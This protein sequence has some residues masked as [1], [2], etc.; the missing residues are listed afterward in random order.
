M[1]NFHNV[2]PFL[3]HDVAERA[4]CLNLAV[5]IYNSGAKKNV[6]NGYSVFRST[7]GEYVDHFRGDHL[8]HLRSAGEVIAFVAGFEAGK[9]Q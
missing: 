4:T 2:S 1:P 5:S 8:V 6:A 3:P 9:T 7:G